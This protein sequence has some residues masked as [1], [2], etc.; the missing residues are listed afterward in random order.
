[1]NYRT[2]F[3]AA[4]AASGVVLLLQ[5]PPC[6]AQPSPS[7]VLIAPQNSASYAFGS[8]AQGSIFVARGRNL[9]PAKLVEAGLYPLSLQLAGTSATVALGG[10]VL[11]CPMVYT[12]S[13][14]IAAILP[15]NTPAGSG[16]FTVT[17]NG[18]TS[19]GVPIQVVKSAVG[20]F[21]ASSSGIG[22]GIVTGADYVLKTPAK[23]AKTGEVLIAW[24]TGLGPVEGGDT[25]PKP[26]LQ[27]P[28]T[29]VFVGDRS[30]KVIYAGRSGCCAGLDQIVFEAPEGPRSCF[31]PVSIR[32]AGGSSN[33]V[34][35]PVSGGG[36][37]CA[38]S[39]PGISAGALSKSLGGDPVTIGFLGIGPIAVLQG[40]GFSFSQ[41]IADQMSRIL[42]MPVAEADVARLVR[43]YRAKNMASVQKIVGKYSSHVTTADARVI[44]NIIRSAISRDQKGAAAL[45]IR[46][47]GSAAIAPQFGSNFPAVGSCMVT[48]RV[49][50]DETFRTRPLDAGTALTVDGPAGRK[51]LTRISNGQYQ[52]LLGP[53]GT[54]T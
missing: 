27:F 15:S 10:A 30:A 46:S 38:N 18:Q 12:S 20:I 14:Q 16:T 29:E 11:P 26:G 48:T 52:V 36:E 5:S 25:A 40:A 2:Q 33:F 54:L 21:T 17:Y 43:S 34:T 53:G 7:P 6:H 19:S 45:F 42:R 9:G 41:G 28:Q 23:P 31:V 8:V 51:T 49:P 4:I 1:M 24:V 32:T 3:L 35:L 22:Q 50:N 47:S 13:A 37:P 39:T 44:R